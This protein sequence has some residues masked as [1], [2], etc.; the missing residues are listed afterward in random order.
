MSA[1]AVDIAAKKGMLMVV[2]AGNEGNGTWHY[3][4]TPADADSCLSIGAVNT[5]GE[6]A[7]FSSYGPS[8]DGQ[9]KP[10]VSSVGWNAIIANDVDGMPTL[11]SGTSYA[12]PNMAGISTC[13]WQAFP[14]ADNMKIIQTLESSAS[15]SIN[16]DN[17]TGYGIP[18]AKKAFVILQKKYF[19]NQ[20]IPVDCN[21]SINLSAKMD[22]TMTIIA[23]RKLS[24]DSAFKILTLFQS[25]Q[26]FSNQ[27]FSYLDHL[28]NLD[29]NSVRY[30]YKMIIGNDTTYFLDSTKIDLSIAC[31]SDTV[32]ENELI[33]YPNPASDFLTVSINNK[34]E[35]LYTLVITN[36]S[37]Q[38]IHISKFP[39]NQTRE[40]K[41]INCSSFSKG[42]YFISFYI[43]GKKKTTR[44][45]FKD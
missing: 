1:K 34:E 18:D 20:T 8:S 25:N 29:Y 38:Q 5:N 22:S 11:G 35:G 17:R 12:C 45:F 23:E 27:H 36:E 14:E 28:S 7:D 15:N 32:F 9:I 16:P 30:R 19:N 33:V 2:A 37:G 13:L 26:S 24:S 40:L 31:N 42:Y 6:V 41:T 43:N 4:N 3:I 21:I 10:S 39:K 44:K